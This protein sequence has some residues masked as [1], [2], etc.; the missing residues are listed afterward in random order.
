MKMY[1]EICKGKFKTINV[2]GE[3]KPINLIKNK[4]KTKI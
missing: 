4:K 1:N 2:R 3:C